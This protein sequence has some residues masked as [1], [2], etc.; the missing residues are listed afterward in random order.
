MPVPRLRIAEAVY[1]RFCTL[2]L[3]AL[4]RRLTCFFAGFA[5]LVVRF[6]GLRVTF[7]RVVVAV[8]RRLRRL[9]CRGSPVFFRISARTPLTTFSTTSLIRSATITD[10]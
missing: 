10:P 2:R 6:A 8:V 9:L 3:A 1:R 5:A 7:A 4:R